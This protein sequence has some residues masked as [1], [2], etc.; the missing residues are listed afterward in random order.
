MEKFSQLTIEA[1]EYYVYL[2]IDPRDGKI[3]YVGKGK[4][5]RVFNHAFCA[6]EFEDGSEKLE[7]I[8]AIQ[9]EGK[10]VQYY[11]VRHGLTEKE[12]FLVESVFIDFLSYE[13]FK[14]IACI[15]NI[16]A[17]H[18]QWYKGIKTAKELEVL[19]A[20]KPLLLQD[21][22]HN[23]LIININKT[24]KRNNELHPN[25]YEA[26]RKSWVLSEQKIKK[27]DFVLGEFRGIIR[28]VFKPEKWI[29]LDNSN[30]IMFEGVEITD[31]AITDVYLNKSVPVK[32]NGAQ[33]PIRYY[34]AS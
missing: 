19:Y 28:A 34:F 3:F 30:R 25:I 26:T 7:I 4:G 21:V 5:N 10:Y 27:I 8:R 9:S 1:L 17:G 15:S 6:I 16:A 13:K 11:I 20:C 2:L 32:K 22:K 33:N 23:L 24:Y 12:A 18:H 29:R 31:P 14:S